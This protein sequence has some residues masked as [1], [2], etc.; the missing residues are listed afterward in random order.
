MGDHAGDTQNVPRYTVIAVTSVIV[1][2]IAVVGLLAWRGIDIGPVASFLA[3]FIPP[4]IGILVAVRQNDRLLS[5]QQE[6]KTNV[7]G[8]L[9]RLIEALAHSAPVPDPTPETEAREEGDG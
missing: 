8:N 7:N 5:T 9:S 6:I 4:T 1:S 2:A 3:G